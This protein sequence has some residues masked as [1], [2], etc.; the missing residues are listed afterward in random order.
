MLY[1]VCGRTLTRSEEIRCAAIKL[2][3]LMLE[4]ARCLKAWVKLGG[5]EVLSLLLRQHAFTAQTPTTLLQLALGSF[6]LE[7]AGMAGIRH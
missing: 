1:A 5:F 3:G 7:S 2:L 6:K 4:D